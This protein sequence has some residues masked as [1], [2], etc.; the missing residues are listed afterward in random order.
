MTGEGFVSRCL[1]PNLHSTERTSNPIFS[2][3]KVKP[4]SRHIILAYER[5]RLFIERC[6]TVGLFIISESVN[7]AMLRSMSVKEKYRAFI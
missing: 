3:Q 1:V 4:G 6:K 2:T 5:K 7:S